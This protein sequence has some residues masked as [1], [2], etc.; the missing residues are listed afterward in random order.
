M[1]TIQTVLGKLDIDQMGVTYAHEHL[2]FVPPAPYNNQDP[3][4]CL[5]RVDVA[6]QE[7]GY[8]HQAGGRT[9][10]EMSTVEMG[11]SPEGMKSISESTGVHIIAATGFN[12]GKFCEA[13][14]SDKSVE[15]LA[16]QMIVDL[17]TGMDGTSIKAGVIKASTSKNQIT[18][19]EQKV[20][21]A[22]IKAHLVTGAPVST[23]TEAGTLALEQIHQFQEGGV[24]PQSLLIGHLDRKLELEYLMSVAATGVFM[25]LDQLSK[26]KYYPDSQRIAVIKH[27]VE[28]GY[29]GQILLSG[30]LAR[31]SYWPCYGFG[32]G[33]GL[34]FILWR[35]VPWMIEAGISRPAVQA[36]LVDNPARLFS[37]V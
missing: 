13:V 23:H 10:V 8:F 5:D 22:A 20:I 19:G 2:L 30:D 34:T 27:L 29:G 6:I 9:I 15:Q 17:S 21:E 28:A 35:F 24:A 31:M 3:D 14:V 36:M 11:R 32:N 26:E 12:K 4:L 37:W 25:G 7:L 33:P 1:P 18:P 16:D